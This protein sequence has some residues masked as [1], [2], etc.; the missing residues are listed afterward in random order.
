M[1]KMKWWKWNEENNEM[2]MIIMKWRIMKIMKKNM[3]V[4]MK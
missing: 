4:I 2:K 1:K 3:I